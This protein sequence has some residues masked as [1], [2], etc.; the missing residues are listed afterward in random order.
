M[1]S[2]SAFGFIVVHRELY[3]KDGHGN[4]DTE[5]LKNTTEVKKPQNENKK[6]NTMEMTETKTCEGFH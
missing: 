1:K 2:K 4:H 6:K 3:V 5:I